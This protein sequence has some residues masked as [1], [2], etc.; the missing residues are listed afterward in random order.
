MQLI[1]VLRQDYGHNLQL[2]NFIQG[3]LQQQQASRRTTLA[4]SDRM[5]QIQCRVPAETRAKHFLT[6]GL[7]LVCLSFLPLA[8]CVSALPFPLMTYRATSSS[9]T[10]SGKSGCVKKWHLRARLHI[11]ELFQKHL[12]TRRLSFFLLHLQVRYIRFNL[13]WDYTLCFIPRAHTHDTAITLSRYH[14]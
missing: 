9:P 7:N 8:V 4:Y 5:I 13:L 10:I 12:R 1:S 14:E 3:R 11:S 6:F 2:Q